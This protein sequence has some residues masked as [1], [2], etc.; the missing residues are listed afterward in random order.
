MTAT[1]CKYH[2]EEKET[3]FGRYKMCRMTDLPCPHSGILSFDSEGVVV[4][5]FFVEE[6][7]KID[8]ELTVRMEEVSKRVYAC[9]VDA[10]ECPYNPKVCEKCTSSMLI[11]PDAV[12]D[13]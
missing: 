7:F 5:C 12:V 4:K 6:L 3:E 13:L 8:P 1:N 11:D 2:G 10:D 9:S